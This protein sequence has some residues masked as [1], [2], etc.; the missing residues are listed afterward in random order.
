MECWLASGTTSRYCKYYTQTKVPI[1][2][3]V[4][5]I[6][7]MKRTT[8]AV[9]SIEL[10]RIYVKILMSRWFLQTGISHT[11][12][13]HSAFLLACTSFIVARAFIISAGAI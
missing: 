8:D 9:L 1:A 13:S 3:C 2:R 6:W 4:Q 7:E 11:A 10:R 5:L 12:H